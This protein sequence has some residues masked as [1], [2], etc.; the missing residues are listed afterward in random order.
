M[1]MS[2]GP[3]PFNSWPHGGGFGWGAVALPFT[4]PPGWTRP[5]AF[6]SWSPTPPHAALASHTNSPCVNVASII[7]DCHSPRVAGARE[8]PPSGQGLGQPLL[9]TRQLGPGC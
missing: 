6:S 7:T 3:K 4:P 5:G 2:S 1:Q 9:R 8:R